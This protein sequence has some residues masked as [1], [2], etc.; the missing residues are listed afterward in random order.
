MSSEHS[1]CPKVPP[2]STLTPESP[3]PLLDLQMIF[4]LWACKEVA[5]FFLFKSDREEEGEKK[6]MCI[7]FQKILQRYRSHSPSGF[8]PDKWKCLIL[9]VFLPALARKT[10]PEPLN[11]LRTDCPDNLDSQGVKLPLTKAWTE[12]NNVWQI[13]LTEGSYFIGQPVFTNCKLNSQ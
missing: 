1:T 6:I 2:A 8:L 7:L 3:C 9:C 12:L 5:L 11:S 4:C 10:D 13:E